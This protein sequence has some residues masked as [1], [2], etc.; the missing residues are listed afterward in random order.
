MTTSGSDK[1]SQLLGPFILSSLSVMHGSN[2]FLLHYNP[3]L[4]NLALNSPASPSTLT[5]W[6]VCC[7]TF[8]TEAGTLQLFVILSSQQTY[9]KQQAN[10]SQDPFKYGGSISK[11]S[12]EHKQTSFRYHSY[13]RVL[14]KLLTWLTTCSVSFLLIT[15]EKL[16]V[17]N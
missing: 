16:R 5:P 13:N 11:L 8:T 9:K 12:E 15:A 4:V 2:T 10:A 14:G 6:F 1:G 3:I 17:V 7:S